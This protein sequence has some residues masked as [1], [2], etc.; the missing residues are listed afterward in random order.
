MQDQIT[1]DI[2]GEIKNALEEAIL[3][4]G[5]SSSELVSKALKQYLFLRRFRLLSERMTAKAQSQGI[6]IE[7]DV[8]DR[9]S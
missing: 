6:Q 2:P 5:V 4:E 9:V 7:R 3:S 8:F 1:V